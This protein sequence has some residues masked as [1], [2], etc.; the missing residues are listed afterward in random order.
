MYAHEEIL[1][2]LISYYM[3]CH[4]QYEYF[5]MNI[6]YY[7]LKKT[8][9]HHVFGFGIIK[10]NLFSSIFQT[11]NVLILVACVDDEQKAV[12]TTPY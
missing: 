3:S 1:C 7:A 2:G 12:N 5:V 11:S 10:V 8:T 4:S 6:R 9:K